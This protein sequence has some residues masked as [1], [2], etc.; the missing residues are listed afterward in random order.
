MSEEGGGPLLGKKPLEKSP[1]GGGGDCFWRDI[2][3]DNSFWGKG[4][5]RR[6]TVGGKKGKKRSS[7]FS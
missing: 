6:T 3:G 1:M 7:V 4:G 2:G 5:K